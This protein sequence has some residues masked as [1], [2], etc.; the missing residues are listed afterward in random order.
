MCASWA[1]TAWRRVRNIANHEPNLIRA[2]R[3]IQLDTVADEV[4]G[5]EEPV[6]ETLIAL[7][8]EIAMVKTVHNLVGI[9]A[10]DVGEV[11]AR[12]RVGGLAER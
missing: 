9:I 1:V 4:A 2:A 10:R 3:R 12:H 7:Q 5:E 11:S 8:D 6:P